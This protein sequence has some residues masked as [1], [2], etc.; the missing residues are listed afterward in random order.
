[1]ADREYLVMSTYKVTGTAIIRASS[2]REAAEKGLNADELGIKFAF[3]DAWGETKMRAE[4]PPL[5][6]HKPRVVSDVDS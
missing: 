4:R 5:G 2:A 6:I 3:S 1:V